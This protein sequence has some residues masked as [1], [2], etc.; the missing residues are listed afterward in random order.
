MGAGGL[1]PQE[2]PIWWCFPHILPSCRSW[3]AWIPEVRVRSRQQSTEG[4]PPYLA[5]HWEGPVDSGNPEAAACWHAGSSSGHTVLRR[6]EL[7]KGTPIHSREG[8][9]G[10]EKPCDFPSWGLNFGPKLDPVIVCS[11]TG[12]ETWTFL[13]KGPRKVRGIWKMEIWEDPLRP[14]WY[15]GSP[16]AARAWNW[17]EEVETL[18]VNHWMDWAL[19]THTGLDPNS[20][21][22]TWQARYQNQSP[23]GADQ[24]V[25]SERRFACFQQQHSLK[26]FNK[27]QCLII[28]KICR[29]Q[30]KIT[31]HSKSQECL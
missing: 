4:H 15:L 24:H 13:A 26:D 8:V 6:E 14:I 9:C 17:P 5:G 16:W 20:T 31:H 19:V 10:G 11:A 21:T 30:P 1:K 28:L 7:E 2:Q 22:G 29:I 3:G 27:T 25:Q 12:M 18:L 23:P